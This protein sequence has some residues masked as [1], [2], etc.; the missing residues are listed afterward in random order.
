M[1]SYLKIIL[2]VLSLTFLVIL[3]LFKVN[4]PSHTI[5]VKETIIEQCSREVSIPINVAVYQALEEQ[6]DSDPTNCACEGYVISEKS[7]Y[8]WVAVSRDLSR[9][10]LNCGDVIVVTKNGHYFEFIVA[11]VMKSNWLRK[12]D[13]VI[14]SN[15]DYRNVYKENNL[16]YGL[17]EKPGKAKI[18]K[19]IQHVGKKRKINIKK[20]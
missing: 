1:K 8:L 10:Y 13:I 17:F 2:T 20:V 3:I 4:E 15:I 5:V 9:D 16:L 14:P 6:T 12:I 19:I 18:F 11:D 7:N